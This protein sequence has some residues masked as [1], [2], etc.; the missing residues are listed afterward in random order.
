MQYDFGEYI[1]DLE[2]GPDGLVYC[3]IRVPV[4]FHQTHQ[5]GA[6]SDCSLYVGDPKNISVK[7]TTFLSYQQH[8]VIRFLIR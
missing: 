4:F 5:D 7:D 6:G 1:A 3:A 2:Q 8:Q